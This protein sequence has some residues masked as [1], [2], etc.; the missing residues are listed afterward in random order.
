MADETP[1]NTGIRPMGALPP[2]VERALTLGRSGVAQDPT[3]QE[4][5]LQR[6]AKQRKQAGVVGTGG[7]INLATSRPRDPM[8]YWQQNNLPYEVNDP[9]QL[10]KIRLYCGHLYKAHPV[11]A[12]AIDI[13]SKYPLSGMELVCKDP[14]LTEFYTELF[15]EQLNYEDFLVDVLRSYWIYGEAWPLGSFNDTLGV[16]EDDELLHP[17]DIRVTKSPFQKEPR[18]E[19]RLPETLRTLLTKRE[20]YW[21]YEKLVR[22]YPELQFYMGEN[23]YMP[24]SNV[25]LQQLAFKGDLFHTRGVPIL[26]R[27]L[28]AAMQEEML[29]SA[30]D[31]I[32]DRL[33]TPLVLMKLGA[34]A[35]DLGTTSPWIPTEADIADFEMSMDAALAG[36]FRVLT[37]HFAV[38]HELIFGRETMPNFDADFERLTERQLQVFG[39]S[40]SMLSGAQGGE[41][42]AADALNRDLVSQLLGSAQRLVKRLFR[43]RAL[44][45]AEAR[46]HWDYEVRN[47]KRYPIM[48]EVLE[49]D[50]ETGE[51]RIVE[52]PKL[53]VPD[54]HIKAMDIRREEEYRQFVEAAVASN[55]PISQKTR[56]TNLPIDLDEEREKVM[57]EQ[58]ANAVAEQETRKEVYSALKAKRL[59]IP[60]DLEADFG[61][62]AQVDPA[63][64]QTVTVT[65]KAEPNAAIP[66]L[67]PAPAVPALVPTEEDVA[68]DQKADE[69]KVETLPRNKILEPG[70]TRPPESDEQRSGMP[71]AAARW[72]WGEVTPIVMTSATIYKDD[73]SSIEVA[74]PAKDEHDHN[75]IGKLTHGPAHVGM[76]RFA[77]VDKNEPLPD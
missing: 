8:F 70:R 1:Q 75:V 59:P 72:G 76:R 34:S 68:A 44:V 73:G 40:K 23:A 18:F 16:W 64:D 51:Q 46:E 11:I 42:Y 60:E 33:Y 4:M 27:G 48:E 62:K 30:Q 14:A 61:A 69:G 74:I 52:Q 22:A 66:T 17:D 19:M 21:E 63:A 49:V 13:Y 56:F 35:Q 26:M 9:L 36:D 6:H 71:V 10:A 3:V 12:S 57:E 5:R 38:E 29:N 24:V 54:L 55:V 7:Q 65:P 53:L 32:A 43:Q 25:L 41:T 47:G 20:P 15:F 28:R 50:E 31:A 67:D 45:V 58:V 37:H 2:E 77:N 39:L